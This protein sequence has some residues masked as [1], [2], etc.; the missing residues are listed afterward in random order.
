MVTSDGLQPGGCREMGP[1]DIHID[2]FLGTLA[3]ELVCFMPKK[4]HDICRTVCVE[5]MVFPSEGE[6][7]IELPLSLQ[8][9][10]LDQPAAP[11]QF[12]LLSNDILPLYCLA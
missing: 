4:A 9:P 8:T 11:Q 7:I 3:V 1:D 10:L 6:M 2:A 5:R 12:F